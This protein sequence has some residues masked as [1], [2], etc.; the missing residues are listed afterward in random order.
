[1]NICLAK[2]LNDEGHI[3]IF[4]EVYSYRTNGIAMCALYFKLIMSTTVVDTRATASHLRENLTSLN[5]C[6]TS[7][8]S[9][10]SLFKLHVKENRQGL[11]ADHMDNL[12]INL[13]KGH[14]TTSDK[15]FVS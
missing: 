9:N 6:M 8:N 10:A 11:K 7:V 2:L 12:M 4:Q 5:S 13:F 1:M 15:Y 14:M 3:K